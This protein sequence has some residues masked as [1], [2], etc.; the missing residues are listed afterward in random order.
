MDFFMRSG[1][2]GEAGVTASPARCKL[3]G[4]GRSAT[5]GSGRKNRRGLLQGRAG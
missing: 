5:G 1:E 3:N 2:G 4:K